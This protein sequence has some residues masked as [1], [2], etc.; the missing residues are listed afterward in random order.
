MYTSGSTGRPKGVAIPHRGIVRLVDDPGFAR[1]EP[2]DTLLLLAPPSFDAS[3]LEIWGA[4]LNGARLVVADPA[5]RSLD[6]IGATLTRHAVTSLWLTAGLFHQMVD[7]RLSDLAGL[8]QLL[9]GG[10]VLSPPHVERLREELPGVTLINGYGPTE[11]TTFTCCH[12]ARRED[13][14][15]AVPIGRPIAETEVRVLGREL[16]P[17]P[18]GAVGEL[19]IAGAGVARGYVGR[20]ALTAERFV[21]DPVG[22]RSGARAYRSGDLVRWRPDGSLDFLGRLDHQVKLR[23]FRVEPG[24][25]EAV[26]AAEPRVR[27][28]VVMVRGDGAAD[29]RLVAY[30]VAADEEG[31]EADLVEQARRSLPAWMVPS[32]IVRLDELPLTANGKVDRRALPDPELAT[33]RRFVAPQSAAEEVVCGVLAEMLGTETVGMEDDFFELGGHSLVA[34]RV[35]ARLNDVFHVE[36]PLRTLF[37]APTAEG[38]LRELE[39]LAGGREVAEEIAMFYQQVAGLSDD[40]VRELLS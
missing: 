15:G 33:N 8:R 12:R 31:L 10:D 1:F 18:L 35:A 40:E 24:E 20:P 38:I 17:V 39:R 5:V 2:G 11:G 28:A 37:E 29:R 36:F 14:G 26:L 21:P 30:V 6:D 13:G 3:T 16:T 7:H 19:L 32:A 23:G 4:L 25:I 9:A 34:T 27:D 22:G